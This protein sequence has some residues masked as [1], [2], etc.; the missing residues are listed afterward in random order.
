MDSVVNFSPATVIATVVVS[1]LAGWSRNIVEVVLGALISAVLWVARQFVVAVEV[2]LAHGT[3]DALTEVV[4]SCHS[5]RTIFTANGARTVLPGG[6]RWFW[7]RHADFWGLAHFTYE[8]A[9]KANQLVWAAALSADVNVL[10]SANVAGVVPP[11]FHIWV[12]RGT[13]GGFQRFMRVRTEEQPCVTLMDCD[14]PF[15]F[16][17]VTRWMTGNTC[18]EKLFRREFSCITSDNMVARFKPSI[19]Y[20]ATAPNGT[21]LLVSTYDGGYN[22]DTGVHNQGLCVRLGKHQLGAGAVAGKVAVVTICDALQSIIASDPVR[23]G[24][25]LPLLSFTSKGRFGTKIPGKWSVTAWARQR[26]MDT[27]I[28][29]SETKTA[30]LQDIER[31]L[32]SEQEY[33]RRGCPY[34][35]SYLLHGPPGTGKTSLARALATHLKWKLA[36]VTL[37]EDMSDQDLV[38][39]FATAPPDTILLFEDVDRVAFASAEPTGT[40]KQG[41]S[42]AGMLNAL[43]GAAESTRRLYIFTTNH[44]DRLDEALVRPGRMDMHVHMDAIRTT[45]IAIQIIKSY[46]IEASVDQLHELATA[47]LARTGSITPAALHEFCVYNCRVPVGEAVEAAGAF[48]GR[49]EM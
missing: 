19:L 22:S 30:L 29:A 7:V 40:R 21:V 13:F 38:S 27:V 26:V 1:M 12:S 15:V 42:L 16:G 6:S 28:M 8:A 25:V 48:T 4:S 31:F 3:Y 20:S 41:V 43:D 5:L 24:P 2:P 17:A 34:K 33:A 46:F 10:P 45:D 18:N 44:R 11:T 37:T 39:A 14:E 32:S 23:G 49:N 36:T 9:H 35:R 47:V